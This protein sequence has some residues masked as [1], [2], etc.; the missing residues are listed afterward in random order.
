[1]KQWWKMCQAW[2]VK[3]AA[4][5]ICPSYLEKGMCVEGY[6]FRKWPFLAQKM[7]REV[8]DLEKSLGNKG[9][10]RL[11]I[12]CRRVTVKELNGYAEETKRKEGR[13]CTSLMTRF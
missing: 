8:P 12:L 10:H 4:C 11:Y 9:Q 5:F 13:R 3:E 1:M 2:E 7:K 6:Y